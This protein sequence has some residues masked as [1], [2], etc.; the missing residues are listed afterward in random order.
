MEHLKEIKIIIKGS[1]SDTLY[2]LHVYS[3][4]D[5]V[6]AISRQSSVSLWHGHLAHMS[7]IGMKIDSHL[8]YL[9][10]LGYAAFEHCDE[11]LYHEHAQNDSHKVSFTNFSSRVSTL[12]G[13][14][15]SN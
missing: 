5:H 4:S 15:L 13:M 12:G 7:E 9:P 3:V 11:C 1:K 14:D 2:P 10:F 6:D 8:G